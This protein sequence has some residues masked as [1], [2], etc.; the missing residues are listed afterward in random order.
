MNKWQLIKKITYWLLGITTVLFIVSGFGITE[1][2]IVESLTFGLFT[3]VLAF[4]LHE[5]LWIPF[6]ILLA[7]HIFQRYLKKI[8]Q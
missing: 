3:K 1:Y 2:R 5:I 4:K 7:F 6:V 8:R